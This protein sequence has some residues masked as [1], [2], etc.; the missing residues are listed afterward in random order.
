MRF[1]YRIVSPM[2]RSNNGTKSACI[3]S[4]GLVNL[5]HLVSVN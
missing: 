3:A 2:P 4:I 5:S 1:R